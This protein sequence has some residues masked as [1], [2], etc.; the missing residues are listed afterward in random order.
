L[1]LDKT[2]V[3][4][5]QRQHDRHIMD[6]VLTSGQFN[7]RAIRLIN[8]C[9]LRLQV[10]TVADITNANGTHLDRAKLFGT[11]TLLSSTT[12]LHHVNQGEPS[13]EA[14]RFWR[15]ACNLFSDQH[16]K[17]QC[18]LGP[19]LYPSDKLRMQHAA[20]Y[21]Q[22]EST[23]Y[24]RSPT[25]YDAF[26][27]TQST[28]QGDGDPGLTPPIRTSSGCHYDRSQVGNS[29][30]KQPTCQPASFCTSRLRRLLEQS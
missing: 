11:P 20:Y 16:G 10:S 19:W 24:V 6:A 22:D 8:Y 5:I 21:S 27:V 30:H 9:R 14:W 29:Q 1:E 15:R 3:T 28:T 4:P 26:F 18:P 7:P 12:K 23:L 2:Y 25:G 17:L 13:A